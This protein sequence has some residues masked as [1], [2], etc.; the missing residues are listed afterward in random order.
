MRRHC[1]L[2]LNIYICVCV[3]IYIYLY[4]NIYNVAARDLL[5]SIHTYIYQYQQQQQRSMRTHREVQ[6]VEYEDTYIVVAAAA[7][8]EEYEDTQGGIAPAYEDTQGATAIDLRIH[9]YEDCVCVR[10]YMSSHIHADIQTHISE[11]TC[12]ST[13]CLKVSALAFADM[14]L[15]VSVYLMLLERSTPHIH[16]YTHTVFILLLLGIGLGIC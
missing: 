13:R 8:V 2:C 1:R 4:M 11:Q 15:Y 9:E 7:V 10:V 14:R 3:C 16:P 12:S 5:L 6:L